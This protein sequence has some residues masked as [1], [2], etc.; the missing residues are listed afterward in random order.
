MGP[1]AGGS[2]INRAIVCQPSLSLQGHLS[3]CVPWPEATAPV[4]QPSPRWPGLA[5]LQ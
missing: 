4:I 2:V 3:Y 1:K 5:G